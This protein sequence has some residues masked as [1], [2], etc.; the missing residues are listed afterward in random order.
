MRNI[1]TLTL[2]TLLVAS[3]GK[4]GGNDKPSISTLPVTTISA[5]GAVINGN[6]VSS[7]GSSIT[8]AGF[9]WD[10][11]GTFTPTQDYDSNVHAASG[12]FSL[13]LTGLSSGTSWYV[14]AYATNSL[15]TT[16]GNIVHFITDT[17]PS[18]YTVTTIAGT[19]SLGFGTGPAMSASFT[20]PIGVGIAPGGVIYVGDGNSAYSPGNSVG[21]VRRIGTDGIVSNLAKIGSSSW[22]LVVDGSGK[23]YDLDVNGTIFRLD[24]LGTIDTLVVG[25]KSPECMDV[26][27]AGNLFVTCGSPPVVNQIVKISPAGVVKLLPAKPSKSFLA[28]GVDRSNN[29]I[30]VADGLVIEKIDTL[31]NTSFIA[32]GNGTADGIGNAAGFGGT[33]PAI[34]VD[35][36]G[37]LIVADPFV[38]K[39]RKVTP[40]GVVTTIAGNGSPGD[41]D[42]SASRANFRAPYDLGLDSQGNIFVS[43]LAAHKIKRLT[44]K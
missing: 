18:D 4:K 10:T 19:G 37:N 24:S 1:R 17:I 2:I 43:D 13:T 30:Y 36:N 29:N 26:D 31:G 40:G 38:S 44:H 21:Y 16:Y 14:R 20:A 25:L 32:G 28:I 3:C 5:E 35:K 34:R 7:G 15:G 22:D 11:S 8:A 23:I 27:S 9:Q 6:I 12:P 33:V 41:V 42:G 39:I